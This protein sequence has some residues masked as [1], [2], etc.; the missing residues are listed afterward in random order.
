MA[1]V[2][3]SPEAQADLLEIWQ[4]IAADNFEAADSVLS[5]IND[6]AHS[7]LVHPG[8]G[9]AREELAS[10]IRSIVVRSY[11]IFYRISGGNIEIVRVLHAARDTESIWQQ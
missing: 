10:G 2:I 6:K 7:L 9:R 8:M 3:T 4:Y 11:L 1:Q 5:E